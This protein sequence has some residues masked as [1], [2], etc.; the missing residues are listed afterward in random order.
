MTDSHG[1]IDVVSVRRVNAGFE[2]HNI[3]VD[4]IWL[5][6]EHTDGKR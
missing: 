6:I 5:D 2:E 4:V 1:R 3:P